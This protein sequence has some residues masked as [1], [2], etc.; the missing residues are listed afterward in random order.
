MI[1]GPSEDL[2]RGFISFE[3][4]ND[5]LAYTRDW[6]EMDFEE[7]LRLLKRT[8]KRN[9]DQYGAL[10]SDEDKFKMDQELGNIFPTRGT[11]RAPI[12]PDMLHKFIVQT[13]GDPA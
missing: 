10:R 13:K 11:H 1:I 12:G 7:V 5:R 8:A 2:C 4:Y 3:W 9:F 6:D